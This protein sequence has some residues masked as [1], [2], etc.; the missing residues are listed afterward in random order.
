MKKIKILIIVILCEIMLFTLTGC[1]NKKAITADD[2][3]TIME[4]KGYNVQDATDQFTTYDRAEKIYIA[5]NTD[6][7]YQIEFYQFLDINKTIYFF[8]TNKT[9]LEVNSSS[10]SVSA[11]S[12]VSMKNYEKYQVTVDGRYKVLSRIDNTLVY[13]NVDS[14]YKDEVKGILDIINY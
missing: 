3:K 14:N 11:D 13:I 4:E 12:S 6:K 5:I 9:I 7:N 1:G 8:E 2:F 10:S